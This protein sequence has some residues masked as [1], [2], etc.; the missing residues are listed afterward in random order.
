MGSLDGAKEGCRDARQVPIVEPLWRDLRHAA[1]GLKRTP[2]FT[3]VAVVTLALCLG[4]NLTIFAV[5]DAVL[6]RPLRF[7][8]SDRLVTVFNDFP[9]AG[10]VH[11]GASLTSYYEWRGRL[12]AFASIS[13]YRDG[14][15]IVGDTGATERRD[16]LRVTPEFFATLGVP[17]EAGRAFTDAEMTPRADDVVMVTEDDWRRFAGDPAG[18]AR[19]ARCGSTASRGP[20]S[21]SC[22]PTSASSLRAR[23]SSCRSPPR[24]KSAASTVATPA[25]RTS[26]GA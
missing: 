17:L 6:L 15:A 1:R 23:G 14:T 2:G 13:A 25:A 4:A 10:V 5:V 22:P 21:A 3:A 24:S 16:V 11:D 19:S 26:S 12:P 20:S 7:P 18:G 8:Q 9:K